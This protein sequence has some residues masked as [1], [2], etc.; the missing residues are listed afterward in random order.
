MH[1]PEMPGDLRH[2]YSANKHESHAPLEANQTEME[3]FGGLLI[4]EF[5]W[6]H[7]QHFMD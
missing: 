2:I 3:N 7:I 5:F 4:I 1:L 6:K